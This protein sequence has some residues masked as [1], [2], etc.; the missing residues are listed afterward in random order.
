MHVEDE[1]QGTA[2]HQIRACTRGDPGS[3]QIHNNIRYRQPWR[4]SIDRNRLQPLK[5]AEIATSK[6]WQSRRGGGRRNTLVLR[7]SQESAFITFIVTM[8]K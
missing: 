4:T 5:S 6:Q 2:L 7:R 3:S 8:A 1:A